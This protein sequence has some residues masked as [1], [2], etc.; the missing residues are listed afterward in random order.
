MQGTGFR[1]GPGQGVRHHAKIGVPIRSFKFSDGRD[2][3]PGHCHSDRHVRH[4]GFLASSRGCR[5]GGIH[6]HLEP[7]TGR[8]SRSGGQN[9]HVTSLQWSADRAGPD[10]PHASDRL[11]PR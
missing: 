2:D 4:R 8:P 10:A 5:W 9:G 7:E 1:L 11:Q 6:G 3:D